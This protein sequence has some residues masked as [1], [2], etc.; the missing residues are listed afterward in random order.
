MF[1][2]LFYKYVFNKENKLLIVPFPQIIVSTSYISVRYEIIE[3]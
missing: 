1:I 2:T 3:I